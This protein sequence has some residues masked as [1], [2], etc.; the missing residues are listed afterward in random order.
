MKE[1]ATKPFRK[2]LFPTSFVPLKKKKGVPGDQL[3]SD[4]PEINYD[5]PR[6][7]VSVITEKGD[8]TV[9]YLLVQ[10]ARDSDSGKYTCNPSN[11]N[12]KTL[13]VHVLNGE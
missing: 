2:P 1:D 5:S 9:S 6:G 10:K 8:R 7:G 11:A 13:I 12:P 4:H 3:S